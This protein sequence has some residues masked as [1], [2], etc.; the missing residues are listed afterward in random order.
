MS[1]YVHLDQRFE[2]SESFNFVIIIISEI[3]NKNLNTLQ[4][5]FRLDLCINT[6]ILSQTGPCTVDLCSSIFLFFVLA[7]NVSYSHSSLQST[8]T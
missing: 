8:T 2:L 1:P 6:Y 7:N 3:D 5:S 4:I